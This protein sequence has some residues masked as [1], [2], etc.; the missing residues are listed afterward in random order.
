MPK[1]KKGEIYGTY[2]N[3][4]CYERGL[5]K[6]K[7]IKGIDIQPLDSHT[8]KI[9]LKKYSNATEAAVND[10]IRSSK[11]YVE[12]EL[13]TINALKAGKPKKAESGVLDTPFY[14]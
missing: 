3:E 4:M 14:G 8:I 5:D 2:N 9:V 6:L 13:E 7:A 12:I 11:G 10:A 1:P